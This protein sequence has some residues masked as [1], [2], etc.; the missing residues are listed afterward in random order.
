MYLLYTSHKPHVLT[1]YIPQTTCTYFIH[2]RRKFLFSSLFVHQYCKLGCCPFKVIFLS[3][4][5]GNVYLVFHLCLSVLA[6]SFQ[7]RQPHRCYYI[8]LQYAWMFFLSRVDTT[9][10][11]KVNHVYLVFYPLVGTVSVCASI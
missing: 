8:C 4:V 5:L 2:P 7:H 3:Y 9:N 10:H 6:I 1:L 11:V